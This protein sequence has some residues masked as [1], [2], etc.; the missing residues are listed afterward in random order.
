L[1]A[2]NLSRGCQYKTKKKKKRREKK[3]KE[4]EKEKKEHETI[5]R[6]YCRD[7]R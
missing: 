1:T 5:A 2:R 6:V 7:K 3:R 4:K